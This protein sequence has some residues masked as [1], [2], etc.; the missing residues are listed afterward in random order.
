MM[1][2]MQNH[3]YRVDWPVPNCTAW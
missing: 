1:K 2:F 3:M